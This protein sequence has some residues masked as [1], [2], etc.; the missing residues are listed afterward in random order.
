MQHLLIF[1]EV[2]DKEPSLT[3]IWTEFG[4]LILLG[5]GLTLLHRWL[6]LLVVPIIFLYAFGTLDELQDPYVGPAMLHEAGRGYVIQ[7]YLAVILALT[8]PPIAL[9]AKRPK[10]TLTGL[11]AAVCTSALGFGALSLVHGET[12]A[13]LF[14]GAWVVVL[15]SMLVGFEISRYPAQKP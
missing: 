4:V 15:I 8:A 10:L 9:L 7:S 11:L 1:A 13:F 3:Q 12:T 2:M 14:C 5:T 6:A